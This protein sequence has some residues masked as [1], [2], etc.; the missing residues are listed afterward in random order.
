MDKPM[1]DLMFNG[2]SV[3]FRVRDLLQPRKKVLEEV[4]IQPGAWVLD[5]G[6]G[7]GGYVVG[8]AER[9]GASGM[10]Y[11]LDIH[12]L[13]IQSVQGMARKRGKRTYSFS[14]RALSR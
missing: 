2:M 10:I 12:P 1:P 8:T 4:D 6:C 13:A 14:K 9:V 5:Y 3:M 11:A 7:P